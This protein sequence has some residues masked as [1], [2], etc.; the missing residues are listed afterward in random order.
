MPDIDR[1]LASINAAEE[2]AYG[3]DGDSELAADRALAIDHYLG[4]NM[5][6]AP[7]GRSQVVDRS[8]FETVQWII[9]SLCRIFANG[10]DVVSLPPIGPDDEVAAKQEAQYLNFIVTQKNPWFD[11]FHIWAT[12]ALVTKNAYAIAYRDQRRSVQIERYERQTPEGLALLLQDR[13]VEVTSQRAYPDPDAPPPAAPQMDPA[14]GQ[15]MAAP[16]APLLYDVEL[17]LTETTPRI[18]IKVIPPE[19]CK[20]SQSTPSQ[21]LSEDCPYFE[22]YEYK[23]LSDLRAEG[24]EVDDDIPTGDDLETEEDTARDQFNEQPEGAPSDPAMRRV[25]AR[26]IWIKHDY[27]EDGI[28]ELQYVVRVGNSILHREEVSRI[29][30][31]CLVPIP[32]PH[33]H[34]G[35]SIADITADISR[36]KTA[37]LR[38]GLD[39]LYLANNPRTAVTDKVNLDDMLVSRPGGL[40]RVDGGFPAN[41]IMPLVTPFVFP[42]AM[43]GLEYM[44]SVRENRTGTNRY[45]TGIDQNALNKTAT[46]IQQLSSMAAQR[47]EQIARVFA[48]GIE[49][50][51]SIVHELILKSGHK[52]EVVQ[53]AGKW[54]EV[55]PATWRKRTDFR[56]SVGFAAG[57]K[58]AMINKLMLILQAQREAIQIGVA[59]PQNVYA[60]LVELT[61]AADFSAPE[62]FWTDP[63]QAQPRPPPQPDVTVMAA[64]QLRAQSLLKKA[65]MDNQTKLQI[66]AADEQTERLK[67]GAQVQAD[68][69]KAVSHMHSSRMEHGQAIEMRQID[70]GMAQ[71][72]HNSEMEAFKREILQ[73]NQKQTEQ[74]MQVIQQA[75]QELRGT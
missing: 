73:A 9:P 58:D 16:A 8:V 21:R 53:L 29:P 33:R 72:Q 74:L 48:S 71:G 44:D 75:I 52:N 12:D 13:D 26:C 54:V 37:I 47:V 43:E 17:R 32:L 59:T 3:S 39:N 64:E 11:L 56:I 4:R 65:E 2:T 23:T 7:E 51:F 34:V 35:L 25:R 69:R 40:V 50:L 42:Q 31:A 61:K 70:A 68:E 57:N 30:V 38:Q 20:V 45:F 62:R 10:D 1:L 28:A 18:S 19:R 60:A 55:D 46:G 22:Y 49:D 14:T 24:F 27:D 36:I 15:M 63:T 66:A 67:V 41:E 6:P 5:D